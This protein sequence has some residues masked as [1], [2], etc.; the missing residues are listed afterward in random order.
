[1]KRKA[2]TVARHL[3]VVHEYGYQFE[4]DVPIA[5]QRWSCTRDRKLCNYM[6]CDVSMCDRH[7]IA[8]SAYMMD[9]YRCLR[10]AFYCT[11]CK[12][13]YLIEDAYDHDQ[14]DADDQDDVTAGDP[15]AKRLCRDCGMFINEETICKQGH[16]MSRN[17]KECEECGGSQESQ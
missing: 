3:G 1:M 13:V 4:C 16:L 6:G 15:H 14:D 7:R 12:R 10:H 9:Y 8:F 2:D 17:R 11:R 5:T